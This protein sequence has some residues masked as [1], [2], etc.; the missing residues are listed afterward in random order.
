MSDYISVEKLIAMMSWV[1]HRIV[2]PS[3]IL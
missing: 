1:I 3:M 2:S